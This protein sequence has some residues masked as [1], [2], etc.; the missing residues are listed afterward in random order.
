[1]NSTARISLMGAGAG[2]AMMF[3]LD[4]ARGSRRRA[5]VK[6]KMA[7]ATRK[8]RD[9]VGATARDV[10]NRWRGASSFLDS[11][12]RHGNADEIDD[13]VVTERIRA[14]LG[15]IS[16]HPRAIGVSV[17]DGCALLT[18]DVLASELPAILRRVRGVRG[19]ARIEN[20]MV[21]HQSAAGIPALQGESD[22]PDRWSTWLR[23]SWSP[24]AILAAGAAT[25]AV[26]ATAISR[27][28][29]A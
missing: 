7:L 25:A 4:P 10:G 24:T 16:S 18:G 26:A 9:T 22:R 23:S 6:D 17:T 29:A 1:M 8:T 5:L 12:F 27:T 15:R 20:L 19:V 11:R 2:A 28:R 21:P 14:A 13:R 3:L